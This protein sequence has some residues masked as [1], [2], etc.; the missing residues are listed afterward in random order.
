MQR[1][2]F[3]SS[4]LALAVAPLV[5]KAAAVDVPEPAG[6]LVLGST[7]AYIYYSET[8]LIIDPDF[9]GSGKVYIGST[10]DDEVAF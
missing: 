4:L 7:D 5:P 9:V 6:G 8:N 10:G 2:G 1:R 3:L